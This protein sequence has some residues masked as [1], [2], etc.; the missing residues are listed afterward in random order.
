MAVENDCC[1]FTLNHEHPKFLRKGE[2]KIREHKKSKGSVSIEPHLPVVDVHRHPPAIEKREARNDE[3]GVPK[4]L[5]GLLPQR[6][7]DRTDG[8]KRQ[9][10]R[11]PAQARATASGPD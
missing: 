6:R 11:R 9:R 1:L 7:H 5:P 8:R 3:V 2:N 10:G 4:F